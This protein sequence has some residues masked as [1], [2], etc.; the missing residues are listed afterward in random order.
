MKCILW[1]CRGANKPQFRRSIRYLVKKFKTNILVVFETHAGGEA[2]CRICCGLGFEN[3]FRVDAC[4]QSGGLWLL[5]REEI[6]E[7][8]VVKSSDQFIHAR[9]GNGAEVINLIVVYAAPSPSRKSG[10]WAALEE[11]LRNAEGPVFVGGDFNTIVR[12]DERSGGNGR[13]SEDFIKFGDWINDM[14][15]IDMR[16]HGNQFTWKRGKTE[17]TFLTPEVKGDARRRPFRFEAAWLQHNEFLDLLTASWDRDIDTRE[18]LRRLE[19]T[20]RKWNKEVFRNVQRRKEDLLM[21]IT[22]IHDKIEQDLSDEILVKEGELLKELEII[23]EQEEVLWL[24]KLRE[25]WC[26]HGDR[27][28]KFFHMSTIIRRKRN[29][30]EKLKKDEIQWVSDAKELEKL[31]VDYFRKLYSLENMDTDI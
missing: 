26:V 13:L 25:K 8:E 23:L 21:E 15:L 29:R 20:L 22:E 24:Q 3:S 6:G 11:V 4:G 30:V 12:I 10:L 27:N 7:L 18:A 14:S 9:I 31:A 19:V 5:W 28:T 16:F 2:A 17:S 1:N